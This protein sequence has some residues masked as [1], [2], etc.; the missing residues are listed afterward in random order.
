LFTGNVYYINRR[1][2]YSLL[3]TPLIVMLRSYL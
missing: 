1:L 3:T 2:T